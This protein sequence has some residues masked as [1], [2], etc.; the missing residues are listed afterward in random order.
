M[1]AAVFKGPGGPAIE[2]RPVALLDLSKCLK[3]LCTRSETIF[4]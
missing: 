3:K 1:L 4:H 2:G